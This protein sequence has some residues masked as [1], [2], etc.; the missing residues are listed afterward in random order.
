MFLDENVH[1]QRLVGVN[2]ICQIM[3]LSRLTL[4][5]WFIN[6]LLTAVVLLAVLDL[7]PVWT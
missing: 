4:D 6:Y 3:P 1:R 5:I 7:L 2:C